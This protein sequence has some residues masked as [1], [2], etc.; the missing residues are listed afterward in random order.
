MTGDKFTEFVKIVKRLRKECPW[1]REQSFATIAPYTIEEA[2]EVADAI[3]RNDLDALKDELGDLLLQEQ[4]RMGE[5]ARDVHLRQLAVGFELRQH[6]VADGVDRNA[7]RDLA[8]V[9]AAHAV[10]QHVQ[11]DIRAGF[12]AI[13]V[14]VADPAGIR[15]G[16]ALQGLREVHGRAPSAL[17]G[18]ANASRAC[19]RRCCAPLFPF[20]CAR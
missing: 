9:V 12:D 15:Q 3:A 1:D 18:M 13:L 6:A 7:A 11:A 2:Y 17:A 5:A 19:R 10:G 8:R 14:V 16:R 20:R 4:R